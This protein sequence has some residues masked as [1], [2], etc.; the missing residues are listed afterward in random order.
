MKS[1]FWKKRKKFNRGWKRAAM[2]LSRNFFMKVYCPK[3]DLV[4]WRFQKLSEF[5]INQHLD[6]LDFVTF[7]RVYGT[8]RKG[9]RCLYV[10][11]SKIIFV[12]NWKIYLILLHKLTLQK[13]SKI[14]ND[15]IIFL[16]TKTKRN[17]ALWNVKTFYCN[18]YASML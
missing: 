2:F 10:A 4:T 5:L 17:I 15:Y 13:F 9:Y 18:A 8:W 3:Y 14:A 7:L 11:K 6:L 12:L 16:T 1:T